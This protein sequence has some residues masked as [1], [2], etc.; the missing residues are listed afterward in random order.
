MMDTSCWMP[1]RE[2]SV[3]AAYLYIHLCRGFRGRVSEGAYLPLPLNHRLT[4][5]IAELI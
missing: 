1:P 2:F 4:S 3:L 5:A